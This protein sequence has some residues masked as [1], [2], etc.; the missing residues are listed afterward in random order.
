V[1]TL[2]IIDTNPDLPWS[3]ES[4]SKKS[5]LT[6]PF[7]KKYKDKL[8][9]T[10]VTAHIKTKQIIFNNPGL[11]WDYSAFV[12]RD[13]L[14][15]DE[16]F[17]YIT[18]Y[19]DAFTF[20][21]H[22]VLKFSDIQTGKLI[23]WNQYAIPRNSFTAERDDFIIAKYRCYLSAYRIQQHWHR[24]RSNPR[25]PVGQ[26]KLEADY[27]SYAELC[28]PT[29]DRPVEYEY[30]CAKCPATFTKLV[31][32]LA[33]LHPD[34]CYCK[35]FDLIKCKYCVEHSNLTA[36][37]KN[38]ATTDMDFAGCKICGFGPGVNCLVDHQTS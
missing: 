15:R 1:V 11:P 5:E 12:Y 36:S 18:N 24:I 34:S 14:T 17:R 26:K 37:A 3:W 33:H 16:L 2:D 28:K 32:F 25:H 31:Q 20:T 4:I 8:N 7:I 29:P 38:T 23:L 19:K 21:S 30:K 22:P 35:P 13:D 6:I 27:S 9:W 10:E